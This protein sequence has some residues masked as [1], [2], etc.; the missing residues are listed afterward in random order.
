[1]FAQDEWPDVYPP[2]IG[3]GPGITTEPRNLVG[4]NDGTQLHQSLHTQPNCMQLG[5][6]T[7]GCRA[8][9][10]FVVTYFA[11]CWGRSSQ[12]DPPGEPGLL[13]QSTAGTVISARFFFSFFPRVAG[14]LL[15]TS[16]RMFAQDAPS[17][18]WSWSRNNFDETQ[19]M[20]VALISKIQGFARCWGGVFLCSQKDPP[21]EPGLL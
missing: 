12:K 5:R 6:D 4:R 10:S 8:T 7:H 9:V 19:R 2:G 18:Y 14:C 21:G 3:R 1:M 15:R 11:R 13:F 16:G 17:G 20:F